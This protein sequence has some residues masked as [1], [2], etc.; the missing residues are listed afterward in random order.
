MWDRVRQYDGHGHIVVSGCRDGEFRDGGGAVVS[1]L[2]NFVSFFV[3]FLGRDYRSN[4][5]LRRHRVRIHEYGRK[6]GRDYFT[7]N[8]AVHRTE[9]RLGDVALRDGCFEYFGR[10]VLARNTS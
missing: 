3:V 9:L 2:G 5:Y 1:Q 8:Y 6:F 7:D 10:I 4:E